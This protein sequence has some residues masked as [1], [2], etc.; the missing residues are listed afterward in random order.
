MNCLNKSSV[1]TGAGAAI[2]RAI[3]A[4]AGISS[5]GVA[6]GLT[7]GGAEVFTALEVELLGREILREPLADLIGPTAASLLATL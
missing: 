5:A 2:G 7:D 6:P 1:G 3:G 4:G